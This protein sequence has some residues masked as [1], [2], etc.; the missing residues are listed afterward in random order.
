[1]ALKE[2]PQEAKEAANVIRMKQEDDWTNQLKLNSDGGVKTRSLYN[3]KTIIQNDDNTKNAIVYDEFADMIVVVRDM[4]SLKID[5]GYWTDSKEAVL[6]N[7]IDEHYSLLFS[8]DNLSDAIIGL[9]K[10]KTINP[11]KKRIESVKWDGVPRAESFFIDYLGAEDNHYVR[12]ITRVWLT[13]AV[14]RVYDPG[15]KFDI[16]PI[17]QGGQGIGKS[18]CARILFPDKFNDTLAGM[19]KQKDDY[20]QLQGSWILEIA[21]LSAMKKTDIEGIKNFISARSDTY[22]NSYGKY[23]TPHQRKCVFIGTTNQTDYL[24]DATGERRFYPIK[25]GVNKAAKNVWKPD[26]QDILQ[27]LAE[28]KTWVDNDEPLYLDQQTMAEAKQYQEEAETVDPTK[29]AIEDYIN[30]PVPTNWSELDSSVKRSFFQCEGKPADWLKQLI[31][32]EREPMKQT[33][34]REIMTVVFNKTV[35][36]YLMGRTNSEAKRIKLI[37]DNMAGWKSQRI[38]IN[39]KQPHGY[40][41]VL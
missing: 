21:E 30:M 14:S 31:S 35:D 39:G 15:C 22:R 19:G 20:Q 7:Y 41:R 27:I 12:K 34:T 6:R 3:I 32:D 25:C 24:K 38:R 5:K 10:Q 8:K 40:V 26:E 37:M 13:G 36:R 33:T 1:M 18:T 4:P 28:V 29:E 17:L 2:L 16:V 9:S 11:V 23:S